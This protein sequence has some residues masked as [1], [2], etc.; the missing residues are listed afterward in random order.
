M[1]FHEQ[2]RRELEA[3]GPDRS[4]LEMLTARLAE[5]SAP[6][7]RRLPSRRIIAA[8]AA[9]AALVISAVAAG[10]TLRQLLAGYLGPFSDYSQTLEGVW[11]DQEQ[12]IRVELLEAVTD[13]YYARVYF[14]VTDLTGGG[15]FTPQTQVSARLEG[16]TMNAYADGGEVLSVSE[17]G[18]TLLV[19]RRLCGAD[20]GRGVTL[21]ISALDPGVRTVKDVRFQPPAS[22]AALPCVE[23]PE[24]ETVLAPGQTPQASPD[25][26]DFSIS[27]MGFDGAGRLHIRLEL[28]PGYLDDGLLSVPYD[29][30]GAQMGSI[31]EI[32][33]VAGGIDTVIEGVTPADLGRIGYIRVYGDYRGPELPLQLSCT[34]P[35]TLE[36]VEQRPV[37]VNR[38]IQGYM[39]RQVQLSP[40][41]VTVF[42]S[43][44]AEGR[45]FYGSGDVQVTLSEGE[46]PALE[47]QFSGVTGDGEAYSIWTFAQPVEL[48]S[49]AALSILG[50]AIPLSQ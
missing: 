14:S 26:G 44:T 1:S 33:P 35:L 34:M 25:T 4:Q 31:A 15:R 20:F 38:S 28:A 16:E 29:Q 3:M 18:N 19:E 50:E 9:A 39:V 43:S 10:P 45:L 2:L 7:R 24:G 17:D 23:T 41:G 11:S 42:Y 47:L 32:T 27:S 49:I 40:L 6:A 13:G 46:P 21:S 36:P 12:G 30:T 5:E 37:A 48:D 22:A 8:L